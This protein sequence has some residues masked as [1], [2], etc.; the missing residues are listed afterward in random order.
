MVELAIAKDPKLGLIVLDQSRFSVLET[1]PVL[2]NRFAGSELAM[3]L[4][5]DV[6]RRLSHWP[7]VDEL[8]TAVQF[9]VGLRD[10]NATAV[11]D[12]LQTIG[13][14]RNLDLNYV[15]FQ[16]PANKYASSGIKHTL[17]Q[18][19]VPEGLSGEVLAYIRSNG[20]YSLESA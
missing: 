18:G 8:V 11:E 14:T 16:A 12:H 4:G 13:K 5:E 3:L 15:V 19:G 1:W 17:R 10:G 2:Q 9:I 6:F 7:R 20:L